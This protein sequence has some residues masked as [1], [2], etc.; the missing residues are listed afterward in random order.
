MALLLEFST[1]SAFRGDPLAL[2]STCGAH[3]VPSGSA[4]LKPTVLLADDHTG[5]LE[6]VS[7]LLAPD[8]QVAG[9]RGDGASAVLAAEQL[10]PDVIVMDVALPLLNGIEATRKIRRAGGKSEIVLLSAH[11]DSDYVQYAFEAGAKGYVVKSR[12]N[13]ELRFALREVLAGRTFV[14]KQGVAL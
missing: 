3:S 10:K 7:E 4:G 13:R 14:S 6:M 8:Y 11:D 5:I 2:T 12:M 1:G 9:I